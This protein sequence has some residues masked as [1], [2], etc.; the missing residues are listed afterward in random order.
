MFVFVCL[1]H[2]RSEA[3]VSITYLETQ[4]KSVSVSSFFTQMC[5]IRENVDLWVF[6][7]P[8]FPQSAADLADF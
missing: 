6:F 1:L 3:Q 7:R 5:V 2:R 8:S 4:T